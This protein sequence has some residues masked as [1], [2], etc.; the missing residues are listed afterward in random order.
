[1]KTL[2]LVGVIVV[3]F[4]TFWASLSS[5]PPSSVES[6][7]EP[8]SAPP[9]SSA[10]SEERLASSAQP[11]SPAV[12]VTKSLALPSRGAGGDGALESK[13]VRDYQ[14]LLDLLKRNPQK[15]ANDADDKTGGGDNNADENAP[16]NAT[17]QEATPIELQVLSIINPPLP[18]GATPPPCPLFRLKMGR[19]ADSRVVAKTISKYS[20]YVQEMCH[21]SGM[22]QMHFTS[23]KFVRFAETISTL[24]RVQP[25]HRVLDIGAGCGS[26]LNF[27]YLKHGIGPSE[28]FDITADAVI[29]AQRHAQPLIRHCRNDATTG[30]VQYEAASFD[31]IISLAVIYH[32][33]RTLVQCQVV[34]EMCRLLRPGGIAYIGQLRTEKTQLYWRKG[35]CTV[36]N[37][38]CS[39][40]RV[41]DANLFR[42]RSFRRNGFFSLIMT[43]KK[44]NASAADDPAAPPAE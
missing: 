27:L 26:L 3:V 29:H 23:L 20:R 41:S 38:G 43:K 42:E 13:R 22:L 6:S 39:L 21:R 14:R 37:A 11:S 10:P 15:G 24:L 7:L 17:P 4:F 2:V 32:I 1:M 9:P 5:S 18:E 40:R 36:T 33:R 30:L 34:A 44:Q 19:D 12:E 31:R 28:G 16:V 8:L 25:G 35:K